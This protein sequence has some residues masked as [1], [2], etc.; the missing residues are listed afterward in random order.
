MILD[1][2]ESMLCHVSKTHIWML[3]N[4]TDGGFH[5]SREHLNEGAFPRT[6]FAHHTDPG[7][8]RYL[9]IHVVKD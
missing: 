2:V 1:V 5:L 4:T 3:P 9:G 8:Q 6:V 7:V